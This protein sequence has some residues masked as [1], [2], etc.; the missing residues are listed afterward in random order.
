[1]LSPLLFLY[2]KPD[3]VI[4]GPNAT[5]FSIIPILLF[6]GL[7]KPK[8]V[9]DV[10]STPVGVHNNS[11]RFFKNLMFDFAIY[12]AKNFF[13]GMTIITELMK[14]EVC[15]KYDINPK[16]IGVWTSGVSTTTF[17]PEDNNRNKMRKKLVLDDKFIVFHHGI[18]SKDRGIIESIKAIKLLENLYP[19]LNFFILG[20]TKFPIKTL[21]T[22]SQT[23]LNR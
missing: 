14:K 11:D 21:I 12:I 4:V 23:R 18:I 19:N 15:Q 17:R 10:R 6:P 20:K 16:F 22:E 9:L 7:K 8:F 2:Q 5:I 1:M 13:H 3:F